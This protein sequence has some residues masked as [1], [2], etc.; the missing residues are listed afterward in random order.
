MSMQ[1][2]SSRYHVECFE[3]IESERL[4]GSDGDAQGNKSA[5]VAS[6]RP[7]FANAKKKMDKIATD[8]ASLGL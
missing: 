2:S 7:S 1:G 8:Y 3:E 4:N 5:A 6:E